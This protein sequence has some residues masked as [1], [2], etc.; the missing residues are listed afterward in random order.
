MEVGIGD[1]FKITSPFKNCKYKY[2][3]FKIIE[4]SHSKKSVWYQDNR[5]N[6]KCRCNRCVDVVN[7]QRYVINIDDITIYMSASEKSREDKLK[8]LL[9]NE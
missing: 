4:V 2:K 7:N 3:V 9:N 1:L 5:T 8:K 6:N